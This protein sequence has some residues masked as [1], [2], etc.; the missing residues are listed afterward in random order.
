MSAVRH[1]SQSGKKPNRMTFSKS[2]RLVSNRQF[3]AILDHRRRVSDS[4]LVLYLAP[5]ACGHPRLGVSVG[6]ACGDAVTRNRLKR[7][8]REAFRLSQDRIPATCDYVLMISGPLT[9]KLREPEKRR[10]VL[11]ALTCQDVQR[12]FLALVETASRHDGTGSE[13]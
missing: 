9:R 3:K 8:L 10:H 12:S 7:L 1:A 6:R 2:K 13:G 4:L 11:A 5:N